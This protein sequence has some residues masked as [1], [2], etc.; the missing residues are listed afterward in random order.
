[1]LHQLAQRFGQMCD[2]LAERGQVRGEVSRS[3]FGMLGH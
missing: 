1:M 2:V 3:A